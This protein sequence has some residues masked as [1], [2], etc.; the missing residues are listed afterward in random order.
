MMPGVRCLRIR[1]D[2]TRDHIYIDMD[3]FVDQSEFALDP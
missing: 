2:R 3:A 1:R